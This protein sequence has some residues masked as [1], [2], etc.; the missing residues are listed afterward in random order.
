MSLIHKFKQGDNYFVLD[1]NTGAVHVVDELVY[2]ILEDEKIRPKAE[3]MK[4]L[5]NKYDK[6]ELSEAYDEIQE[7][8]EEG[9]LYSEDQY[10]EIAKSSMDDRDYIK[11]LCL[12]I[13]NY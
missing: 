3:V 12:N 11:A 8:A 5:G 1:V 6:D 13:I 7:L 2:D 9:V 10:E 4:A